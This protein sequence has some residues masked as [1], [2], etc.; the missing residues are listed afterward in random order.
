MSAAVSR[1][2][3]GIYEDRSFAGQGSKDKPFTPVPVAYQ[4]KAIQ[5]LGKYVFAPSAF[6]ADAQLFPYLQLQRR[7]FDFFGATEDPKPQ[8]T[9]LGIQMLVLAQVFSPNALQRINSTSLYGNTYSVAD[10]MSD[11]T[12]AIFDAD[13]TGKVNLYR[14]DIQTVFVKLLIAIASSSSLLIGGYDDPSRAAALSTLKKIK[15]LLATTVSPDEQT[16]AHRVN[17]NFLINKALAVK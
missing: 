2:I 4:K 17:L 14:Q 12:R 3:G 16:R 9:V 13:R 5:L 11:F 1:Y 6:D 10:M 8:T 15:S 7:G